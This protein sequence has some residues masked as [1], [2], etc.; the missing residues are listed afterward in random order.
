MYIYF[1]GVH[2]L[3]IQSTKVTDSNIYTCVAQNALGDSEKQ[4]VLQ[5]YRKF[6]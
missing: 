4:F 1:K 3:T 6:N 2:N 5:V